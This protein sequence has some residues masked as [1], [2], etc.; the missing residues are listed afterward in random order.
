MNLNEATDLFVRVDH[1]RLGKRPG[2][3]VAAIRE[4]R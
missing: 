4:A 1:D 3:Y 2:V